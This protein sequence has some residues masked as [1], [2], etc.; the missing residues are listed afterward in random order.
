MK[1]VG[2]QA[3]V[4]QGCEAAQTQEV[5]ARDPPFTLCTGGHRLPRNPALDVFL[6]SARLVGPGR[7]GAS[8]TAGCRC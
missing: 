5:M 7:P 3:G 8:H 2:K 6:G 4:S 1:P